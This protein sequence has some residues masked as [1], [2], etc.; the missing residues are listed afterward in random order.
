MSDRLRTVV[1]V[2]TVTLGPVL[3]YLAGTHPY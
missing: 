1:A 2:L 3:L